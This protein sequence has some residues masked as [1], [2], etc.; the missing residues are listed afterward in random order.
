MIA[1]LS[2]L[3]MN[4]DNVKFAI[5]FLFGVQLPVSFVRAVLKVASMCLFEKYLDERKVVPHVFFSFLDVV[6]R[7]ILIVFGVMAVEK[8]Y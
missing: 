5:V 2:D 4:D 6:V 3:S 8:H 7:V 1:F